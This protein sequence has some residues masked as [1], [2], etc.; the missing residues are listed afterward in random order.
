MAVL[1]SGAALASAGAPAGALAHNGR[2]DNH[3]GQH[4]FGHH[5][6]GLARAASELGVTKAQLSAALQTVAAQEKSAAKPAS[7]KTLVAQQLQ[8]TPDQLNAAFTQART[9]AQSKDG[10]VQAVATAL[11]VDPAHVTSALTAARTQ[12]QAERKAARDAFDAALA[13]QLNVP[14]DKVAAAFGGNCGARH[15]G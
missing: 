5:D 3:G 10:F 15:D 14:A 9:A 2:G 7:F 12:Q 13:Q 8:V 1:L 11:Q 6:R 4:A